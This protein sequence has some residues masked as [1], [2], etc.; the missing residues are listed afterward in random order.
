LIAGRCFGKKQDSQS[1]AQTES[2][3][4]IIPRMSLF[5]EDS[6]PFG[7]CASQPV[8]KYTRRKD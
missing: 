4:E 5:L 1:A 7:I 3:A 8:I 2:H 6:K